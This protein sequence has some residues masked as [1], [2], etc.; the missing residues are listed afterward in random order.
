MTDLSQDRLQTYTGET[1]PFFVSS[2][3]SFDNLEH[4]RKRVSI[5]ALVYSPRFKSCDI[6]VFSKDAIEK[7]N[8]KQLDGKGGSLNSR[9]FMC[10]FNE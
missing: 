4:Q 8:L 9:G 7:V 1:G 6:F 5:V 2:I 3:I 10:L